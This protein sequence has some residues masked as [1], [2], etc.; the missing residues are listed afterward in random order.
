M[1]PHDG[2]PSKV[3]TFTPLIALL[4]AMGRISVFANNHT[5]LLTPTYVKVRLTGR[6]TPTLLTP[7]LY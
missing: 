6:L 1:A 2:L 3:G 5:P 7:T 4:V